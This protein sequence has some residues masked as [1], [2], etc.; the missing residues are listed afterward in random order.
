MMG[1]EYTLV[2]ISIFP[3]VRNLIGYYGAADMVGIN[4]FTNVTRVLEGFLARPAV[5]RGLRIPAEH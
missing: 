3:W 5:A 1:E 4:D 2:D